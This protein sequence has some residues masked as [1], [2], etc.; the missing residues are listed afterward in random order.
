LIQ[1]G[2]AA[3]HGAMLVARRVFIGVLT[4]PGAT[5]DGV[6]LSKSGHAKMA[7]VIWEVLLPAYSKGK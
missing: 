6:H 2:L 1:R 5:L 7:E 4:A 3:K